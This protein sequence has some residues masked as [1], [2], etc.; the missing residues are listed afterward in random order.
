GW[1]SPIS[2]EAIAPEDHPLSPWNLGPDN[3]PVML[4]DT[5]SDPNIRTKGE[6][7]T[8]ADERL[9]NNLLLRRGVQYT[10]VPVPHLEPYDVVS[11]VAP[12]ETT[13]HA[14]EQFTVPLGPSGDMSYG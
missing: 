8:V 9:A 5:Y 4:V 13:V 1:K 3:A 14:L 2:A 11:A 7:Q 6:A 10:G 12:R